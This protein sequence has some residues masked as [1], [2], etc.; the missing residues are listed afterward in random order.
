MYDYFISCEIDLK[1]MPQF[2]FG[3]ESTL[4]YRLVPDGTKTLPEPM[5]TK[6]YVAIWRQAT[7]DLTFQDV[8]WVTVSA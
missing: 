1:W 7:I 3:E 2:I 5:L 8:I 4:G 6:I